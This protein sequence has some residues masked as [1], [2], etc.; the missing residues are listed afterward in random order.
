MGNLWKI[1][2]E[3]GTVY[4]PSEHLTADEMMVPFPGH[5][6]FKIYMPKKPTKYGIKVYGLVDI[7]SNYV[8]HFELHTDQLPEVNFQINNLPTNVIVMIDLIKNSSRITTTNNYFTSLSLF[9]AMKEEHGF[10]AD[11]TINQ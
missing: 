3:Y 2:D 11:G 8:F 6:P 1:F 10:Q 7:T 9:Q 4:L 5:C